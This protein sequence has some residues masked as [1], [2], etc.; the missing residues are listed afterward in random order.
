MDIIHQIN[1]YHALMILLNEYPPLFG[2]NKLVHE[3]L[4]SY[5]VNFHYGI[6]TTLPYIV[7]GDHLQP[8][9]H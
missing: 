2:K 9:M 8:V 4:M 6:S 1:V 7:L 3:Q 5:E